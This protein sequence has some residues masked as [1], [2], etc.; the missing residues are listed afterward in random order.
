MVV[1]DNFKFGDDK[2]IVRVYFFSLFP[3]PYFPFPGSLFCALSPLANLPLLSS[4]FLPVQ[5]FALP[6]S[7]FHQ[8]PALSFSFS[9]STP[10][11]SHDPELSHA[12]RR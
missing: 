2:E 3:M 5:S 7:I 8:F 12:H 10:P 1:Q 4:I 11:L 6:S 9:L